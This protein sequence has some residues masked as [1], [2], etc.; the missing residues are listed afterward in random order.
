MQGR[1]ALCLNATT[2]KSTS[3]KT[4]AD[5]VAMW[6]GVDHLFIDEV[7]MIGCNM[8][9]DIHN[10]LV[11]ATGC[12]EPFGG[13]NV[14]FDLNYTKLHTD[15]PSGQKTVLGKLLWRSVE[16]VVLLNEQMRQIGTANARFVSLLDRL[17]DG[18]C[19]D[20]DFELLNTRLISTAGEDLAN[21]LWRNAPI[22]VS[23]NAIKD[24]IN[25]RATLAFAP[26][27]S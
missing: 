17:R 2:K 7:S 1:A 10:A 14:I 18:T 3:T 19:T 23:E 4:R 12:T 22:I 27:Q 11:N 24:A 25:V 5:L 16:T 6:D 20:E 13:I 15:A 21:E 26:K 8:M 9:V